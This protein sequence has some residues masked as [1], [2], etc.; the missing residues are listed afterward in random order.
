MQAFPRLLRRPSLPPAAAPPV[1]QQAAAGSAV[2][3]LA[4]PPSAPHAEQAS[5][6]AAQGAASAPHAEPVALAAAQ[7]AAEAEEVEYGPPALYRRNGL[8]STVLVER[9]G[10]RYVVSRAARNEAIDAVLWFRSKA[11]WYNRLPDDAILPYRVHGEALARF[12]LWF[13]SSQLAQRA[14]ASCRKFQGPG[15]GKEV[16]ARN[17]RSQMRVAL[18]EADGGSDWMNLLLAVGGAGINEDL[19][20]CYNDEIDR[21]T[22]GGAH[23]F[24]PHPGP[25][26]SERSSAAARGE[27]LPPVRGLQHKISAAHSARRVARSLDKLL[28]KSRG[29]VELKRQADEAWAEA[30]ALSEEAGYAY[31]DRENKRQHADMDKKSMVSDVL[32]AYAARRGLAYDMSG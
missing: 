31:F 19:V 22:P 14:Y 29:N 20:E 23:G 9:R 11:L 10:D 7:G 28:R 25:R 18:F 3:P 4:A 2:V 30:I 27:D 12:K 6:A 24:E 13:Q 1:A 8:L 21:R 17:L 26:L 5:L 32:Q 16:L 15:M